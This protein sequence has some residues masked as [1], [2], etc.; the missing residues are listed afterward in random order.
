MTG[1]GVQ[2]ANPSFMGLE[3]LPEWDPLGYTP[4]PLRDSCSRSLEALCCASVLS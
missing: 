1:S 2:M 3:Q 4:S